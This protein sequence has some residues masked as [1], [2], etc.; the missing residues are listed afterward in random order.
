MKKILTLGCSG[1]GK[2]TL[3]LNL[4]EILNL[5]VIHL[6]R[7]YWKPGWVMVKKDEWIEIVKNIIKKDCWIIDGNFASTLD[8]RLKE[9]DTAV[10]LDFP[11]IICLW[12]VIK[13]WLFY[14]GRN[15]PDVGEG[16]KE[17]I[18]L[19][20]IMW[21][22]NFNRTH[23]EIMLEKLGKEKH[24]KNIYILKNYKEMNE[25]LNNIKEQQKISKHL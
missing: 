22:W 13:R 4:G 24:E 5:E 9:A 19:E 6:D 10:Y 7:L 25:F 17:K 15:R 14:I 11:R 18:D 3:A 23:R 1:S 12:Q 16:C 20:F 21:I 8:T 2:T